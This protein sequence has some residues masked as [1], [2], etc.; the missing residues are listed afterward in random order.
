MSALK[1]ILYFQMQGSLN[2]NNGNITDPVLQL[3]DNRLREKI[4][5]QSRTHALLVSI[6]VVFAISWL[7][8]NILNVIL[9]VRN[10][11][12]VSL[13]AFIPNGTE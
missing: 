7:P 10:I 13:L 12:S 8:L 11:F 2:K 5:K 6:V 9:D 3:Q 4:K 1:N